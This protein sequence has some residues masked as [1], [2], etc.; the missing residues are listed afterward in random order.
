MERNELKE[1]MSVLEQAGFNPMICN[2]S[3]HLSN[4]T[5]QCGMPTLTGDD[6]YERG[7][8]LPEELVGCQPEIF[9]PARGDSMVGAGF[10]EGDLL[11]LRLTQTAHDGDIVVA[12]VDG[13]VTVKVFFT[14]DKGRRW[15]VPCNDN[16][17][18]IELKAENYMRVLG[19]VIGVEKQTLRASS[20]VCMKAIR[21]TLENQRGPIVPTSEVVNA[22]IGEVAP[23]VESGRQWY[24]VYR[25]LADHHAV[26][27]GCY[28]TFCRR[29]ID[30]VPTH[31]HLP[32]AKELGRM[33]VLSFRKRVALWDEAD[34]PVRGTTFAAYLHIAKSTE[35]MIKGIEKSE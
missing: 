31:P 33:A 8:L 4:C 5:A 21:R 11:R 34:A 7:I 1:V 20:S 18:A 30:V 9:V 24:A 13:A 15:L 2:R 14:D 17:D 25:A 16:Y 10:E 6:S 19:V 27:E 3:I 35:A 28:Q 22:V 26:G 32:M 29:V 12:S 23:M